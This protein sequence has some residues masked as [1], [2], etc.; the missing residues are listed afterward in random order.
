MADLGMVWIGTSGWHY[1]HWVGS[2]Y[3]DGLASSG[4][5]A[6]YAAHFP[7]VEINSTFY[8]LPK[9]RTVATWCNATPAGFVFSCKASGYITHMK[10]LQHTDDAIARLLRS[11]ALLGDRRGPVLF[12][13]PPR[14]RRDAGRLQA[15]LQRLPG[16]L[17]YAF[18]FRD[19]SWFCRPV[20]QLLEAH[21]VALCLYDLFGWRSPVRVTSNWVYVRLHGPAA[22][23]GGN[24][25]GRTLRGWA[26]RIRG[27]RDAGLDVYCYFNN[28]RGGCAVT[29][30]ARLSRMIV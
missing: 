4:Y 26:T 24:Y 23:Y 15:F 5:L 17:Q 12:Q 18:E 7:T 1:R 29:N 22:G 19:R 16:G 10:K 11:I 14:W 30:A 20:Y 8:G 27:W 2:F 25:D 21:G 6:W 3:P 28:D 13:L 9:P